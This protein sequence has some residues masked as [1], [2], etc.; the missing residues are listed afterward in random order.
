MYL[1]CPNCGEKKIDQYHMPTGA[2][3]CTACGYTAPSKENYNP[4]KQ[5]IK[6][7]DAFMDLLYLAMTQADF[8]NGVTDH[9][10]DE[11]NLQAAREM[12]RICT[13]YSGVSSGEFQEYF[14]KRQQHISDP[15]LFKKIEG[16]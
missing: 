14:N 15:Q 9:G 1:I 12:N 8:R 10:V 2:I 3:W 11:G 4:F 13:V 7:K 5:T 16:E 6:W